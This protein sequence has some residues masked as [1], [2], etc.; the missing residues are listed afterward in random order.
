MKK[1]LFITGT[2]ADYGKIKSLIKAVENHEKFE[3]YI[4]VSGMHLVEKFGSTYR[5]V[6]KDNYKNVYV[7]FSQANKG[8]MS[9]DLGNVVCNLTGYVK[10]IQPDMVVVH[11]DRIDALAGAVVGAL[12]NIKVAH[13]EG[14]EIS[15]TI[16][17]SIRH[18]ISK[19]AHIHLVSNKNARDRLQQLGE[20]KEHIY[21]LGSPDIDIMLS[22][23]LPSFE[24]AKK[25]YELDFDQYAF[26]MYHPVTTEFNSLQNKISEVVDALI[27]SQKN[28]IVVFPN[29]DYGSEIILNE[30]NRLKGNNHFKIY[31]SLRFEYFLTLLKNAEFMIGNSSAGI[32]ETGVYGIPTIDIGNRQ[33]GRYEINVANIQHTVE[34][35]SDILEAIGNVYKYRKKIMSYGGGDSMSRFISILEDEAIWKYEIQKKFVDM[36]A[37]E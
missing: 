34:S 23:S 29:N 6:L 19:F 3:A 35:K 11:G 36:H 4:Y 25:R 30:Y 21:I 33:L 2:R 37:T 28:Y 5:E 20:E 18:A 22:E 8:V 10:H 26:F 17:E 27:E 15:G 9:Y 24:E 16:D 1:I 32:R 7:D 12:N 14:G 13:I 31:P